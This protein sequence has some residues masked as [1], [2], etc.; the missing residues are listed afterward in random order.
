MN[1]IKRTIRAI[2]VWL[3]TW[4]TIPLRVIHFY[5]TASV[6]T[7]SKSTGRKVV[8]KTWTRDAE[9]FVHFPAHNKTLWVAPEDADRFA[10]WHK[11]HR[12]WLEFTR[13]YK[14]DKVDTEHTKQVRAAFLY[15]AP[16]GITVRAKHVVG[17]KVKLTVCNFC[18]TQ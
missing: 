11:A 18:S 14:H 3:R 1:S 16:P 12:E 13:I 15:K 8:N 6:R 4:R 5:S 9:G 17:K 10:E 2:Y 7:D